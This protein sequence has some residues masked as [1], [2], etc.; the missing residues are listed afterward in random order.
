[1]TRRVRG[2]VRLL[3]AF[4]FVSLF[5]RV[6]IA[7]PITYE[8]EH[9]GGTDWRYLYYADGR[10]WVQNDFFTIDFDFTLYS[11]L[12][13]VG[14]PSDWDPL[15]F[16]PE[17]TPLPMDGAFDAMALI[18]SPSVAGPFAV[19][20]SWLGTGSPGRQPLRINTIDAGLTQPRTVPEPASLLLLGSGLGAAFALRRRR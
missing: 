19:S 4:A 6:A 8:I 7:S 17:T 3:L 2:S 5:A 13:V 18:D 11:N 14:S 16:Q 10:S 9:L 12:A 15:V 1:M 20:F